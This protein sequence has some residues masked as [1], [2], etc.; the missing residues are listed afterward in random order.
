[1]NVFYAIFGVVIGL[2]I[3][4]LIIAPIER[5]KAREKCIRDGL[6]PRDMV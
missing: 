2:L 4:R 6:V 1:M 5:K 3:N